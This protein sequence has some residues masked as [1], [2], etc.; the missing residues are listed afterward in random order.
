MA[1]RHAAHAVDKV[2][3]IT[4][5]LAAGKI[6]IYIRGDSDPSS[7]AK[8]A[9]DLLIPVMHDRHRADLFFLYPARG[10][11]KHAWCPSWDQ[12][13]SALPPVPPFPILEDVSYRKDSDL[14]EYEGF[15]IEDCALQGFAQPDP[16]GR[17]RIGT[18]RLVHYGTEH[19]CSVAAH[20][21]EPIPEGSYVLIGDRDWRV[22]Y[23]VVWVVG[24]L[25]SDKRFEKLSV[26]RTEDE[27]DIE[28]LMK[29]GFIGER[30]W[31]DLPKK[32]RITLA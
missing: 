28:R 11:G 12:V 4:H 9:W 20:H 23:V 27:D 21:Q 32:Q 10:N 24:T 13:S 1:P 19:S 18:L 16:D 8:N 2:G 25:N 22:P 30:S 6:P 7:A 29:F 31:S 26:L 5:I 14:F 17:C 3:G 15:L